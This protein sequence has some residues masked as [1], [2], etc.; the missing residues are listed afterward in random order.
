MVK[1]KKILNAIMSVCTG[2]YVGHCIFTLW[3]YYRHPE[4]Y[5]MQSAPWYTSLWVYGLMLLVVVLICIAI[6][7]ILRYIEKRKSPE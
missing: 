1:I 7:I 2:Y 5:A 6:K 4:L 3:N